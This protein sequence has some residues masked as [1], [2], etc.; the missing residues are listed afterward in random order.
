MTKRQVD[1]SALTAFKVLRGI[2]QLI[3]LRRT[4]ATVLDVNGEQL[5]ISSRIPRYQI[6]TVKVD[7]ENNQAFRAYRKRF[8]VIL[9]NLLQKISSAKSTPLRFMAP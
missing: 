1:L 7:F 9:K 4:Q 3:T 2:T 8:D 5:Q 6:C